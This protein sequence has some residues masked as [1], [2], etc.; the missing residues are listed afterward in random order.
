[1]TTHTDQAHLA[2]TADSTDRDGSYQ[3]HPSLASLLDTTFP[4]SIGY[5]ASYGRI[6]PLTGKAI[7]NAEDNARCAATSM[8]SGLAVVGKLLIYADT[9][10]LSACDWRSLGDLITTTAE[11]VNALLKIADAASAAV[12]G[13]L[14]DGALYRPAA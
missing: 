12:P 4:E 2:Q 3:S 14:E 1:M 5:D 9:R 6:Y 8:L 7:S 10:E 11:S 13:I